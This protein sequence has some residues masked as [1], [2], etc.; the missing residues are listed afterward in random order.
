[1]FSFLNNI[2]IWPFSAANFEIKP[3]RGKGWESLF[4]SKLVELFK[5]KV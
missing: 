3:W 5:S 1:M 2:P 4:S